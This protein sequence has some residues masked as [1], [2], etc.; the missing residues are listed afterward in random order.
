MVSSTV[1]AY[2][3]F[4][5]VLISVETSYAIP[6]SSDRPPC[7]QGSFCNKIKCG[8]LDIGRCTD[9]DECE[10][11]PCKNGGTCNNLVANYTCSCP[12]EWEGY[13]CNIS[14][15]VATDCLDLLNAGITTSGKYPINLWQTNTMIDVYCDMETDGG[16]WTVFQNRFDGSLDFYRN[17]YQ[18]ENGFGEVSLDC[19]KHVQE[20]ATQ[21]P[22][23]L[24]IHLTD[25]HDTFYYRE[26]LDFSLTTS[27]YVLNIGTASGT[28]L[29]N[30]FGLNNHNGM[31]FSTFDSDNDV[32]LSNCAER[33]ESGWW[34]NA[35]GDVDLNSNYATPGAVTIN[36]NGCS[37]VIKFESFMFN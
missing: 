1:R 23:K 13:N 28:P 16:G 29:I 27:L 17:F 9:I 18:Y 3:A 21:S 33:I 34:Y 31:A 4:F 10:S 30:P 11:N 6:C 36:D 2:I 15:F 8:G 26:F 5:A 14:A 22:T 20:I 32:D 24:R 35:C 25:V 7:P 12:A 37:V 19:L